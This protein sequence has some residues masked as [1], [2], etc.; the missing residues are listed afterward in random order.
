M[1]TPLCFSPCLWGS[2]PFLLWSSKLQLMA[3]WGT[4]RTGPWKIHTCQHLWCAWT[5]KS[6]ARGCTTCSISQR[7][8]LSSGLTYLPLKSTV[9][10]NMA[11]A[12]T[13]HDVGTGTAPAAFFAV[14]EKEIK[15]GGTGGCEYA[16]IST[17]PN[18]L[19]ALCP[20]L[21]TRLQIQ[22]WGWQKSSLY[23]QT[24]WTLQDNVR[25]LKS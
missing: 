21:S 6:G 20:A 2:W 5:G 19:G 13:H 1:P 16:V 11:S 9:V 7:P 12:G 8:W 14:G 3:C 15:R 24:L 25:W 4:G 23:T 17:D 10:M 18:S 22:S